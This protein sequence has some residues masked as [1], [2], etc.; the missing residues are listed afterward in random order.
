MLITISGATAPLT[1]SCMLKIISASYSYGEYDFF[2]NKKLICWWIMGG[3]GKFCIFC[4]FEI[5]IISPPHI[6]STLQPCLASKQFWVVEKWSVFLE[7]ELVYL[8]YMMSSWCGFFI[9]WALLL[10]PHNSRHVSSTQSIRP[11]YF[12]IRRV[13][14]KVHLSHS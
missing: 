2:K 12:I 11:N 4:H 1:H 6:L 5:L 14:G 7:K 8:H 9:A 10:M 3:G 13:H